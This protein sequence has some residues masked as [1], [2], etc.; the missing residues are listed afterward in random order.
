MTMKGRILAILL[1]ILMLLPLTACGGGGQTENTE[2]PENTA[3]GTQKPVESTA[4]STSEPEK[5]PESTEPQGTETA[6]PSGSAGLTDKTPLYLG[7]DITVTTDDFDILLMTYA[8]GGTGLIEFDDYDTLDELTVGYTNKYPNLGF[9]FEVEHEITLGDGNATVREL[10]RRMFEQLTALPDSAP[11]SNLTFDEFISQLS[12]LK[13]NGFFG[14]NFLDEQSP[15]YEPLDLNVEDV[16]YIHILQPVIDSNLIEYSG[17]HN[18]SALADKLGV[19]RYVKVSVS[20]GQRA[21]FP[22]VFPKH[23][24]FA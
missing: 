2:P 9:G 3:A 23:I 5:T 18:I 7:G 19:P 24:M 16:D 6:E 14:L 22:P 8:G 15:D 13:E 10:Y 21:L 20:A 12:S 11:Y 1:C 17:D 4:P